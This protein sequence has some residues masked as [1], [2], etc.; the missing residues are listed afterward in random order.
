MFDILK[1]GEEL[2]FSVEDTID[3][4]NIMSNLILDIKTTDDIIK[5]W[6]NNCF[7]ADDFDEILEQFDEVEDIKEIGNRIFILG[8]G[9]LV[10]I[11]YGTIEDNIY[12]VRSH[13]E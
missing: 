11:G 4:V 13:F 3:L 2:E 8:S 7:R 5:Y 6:V 9:K 12:V 10:V 1:I